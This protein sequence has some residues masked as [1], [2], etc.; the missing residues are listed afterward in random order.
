MTKISKLILIALLTL[1][2]LFRRVRKFFPRA[3]VGDAALITGN[4]NFGSFCDFESVFAPRGSGAPCPSL[5]KDHLSGAGGTNVAREG[6]EDADHIVVRG[7]QF[8]V[9][10]NENLGEEKEHDRCSNESAGAG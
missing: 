2:G 4:D 9:L 6:S 3:N 8:L 5:R 1:F 10:A 7:V